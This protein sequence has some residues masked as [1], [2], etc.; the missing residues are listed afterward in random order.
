MKF[1]VLL[2][3]ALFPALSFIVPLYLTF[4][5]KEVGTLVNLTPTLVVNLVP[6]T[7]VLMSL[8]SFILGINP[9]ASVLNEFMLSC[10]LLNPDI[11]SV[12]CRVAL[13]VLFLQIPNTH[14]NCSFCVDG[15]NEQ[16]GLVLSVTNVTEITFDSLLPLPLTPSFNVGFVL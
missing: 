8:V 6:D 1:T 12:H 15:L 7:D 16:V 5:V 11:L 9:T 2:I 13:T 10:W 4:G 3:V 14:F